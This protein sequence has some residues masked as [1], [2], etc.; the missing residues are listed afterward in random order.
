LNHS[1][2]VVHSAE[3]A[4]L[5]M[6]Q[7]REAAL[8]FIKDLPVGRGLRFNVVAFGSHH[9]M[10]RPTCALFDAASMAEAVTWVQQHVTAELGGTEILET[11]RAVY[12]M[13]VTPGYSRQIIFLTGKSALAM[14]WLFDCELGDTAGLSFCAILCASS[15]AMRIHHHQ[16]V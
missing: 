10:W 2:G 3:V 16:S 11:F 4:L 7:A 1:S 6:S 9:V 12:A 15:L 5:L 14:T 13:P 8:Y